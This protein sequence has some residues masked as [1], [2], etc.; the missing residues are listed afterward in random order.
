MLNKSEWKIKVNEMSADCTIFQSTFDTLNVNNS[1]LF[2]SSR[3]QMNGTSAN[4][5]QFCTSNGPRSAEFTQRCDTMMLDSITSSDLSLNRIARDAFE[6]WDPAWLGVG[7]VSVSLADIPVPFPFLTCSDTGTTMSVDNRRSRNQGGG[8]YGGYIY[9]AVASSSLQAVPALASIN[10][11]HLSV[12]P[13]G[14]FAF[15]C[16]VDTVITNGGGFQASFHTVNTA[17]LATELLFRT[18]VETVYF[19]NWQVLGQPNITQDAIVNFPATQLTGIRILMWIDL[20]RTIGSM[21]QMNSTLPVPVNRNNIVTQMNI[22]ANTRNGFVWTRS[23]VN[24]V[25][26]EVHYMQLPV[27]PISQP[28]YFTLVSGLPSGTA[29]VAQL[30]KTTT[31]NICYATMMS[32]TQQNI[33]SKL[34]RLSASGTAS[35]VETSPDVIWLDIDVSYDGNTVLGVVIDLDPLLPFERS[36]VISYDRGNTWARYPSGTGS[37]GLNRGNTLPGMTA[38]GNNASSLLFRGNDAPTGLLCSAAHDTGELLQTTLAAYI[39]A[40]RYCILLANGTIQVYE[41]NEMQTLLFDSKYSD[42]VQTTTALLL[43]G[44]YQ[45]NT[46]MGGYIQIDRN[47]PYNVLGRFRVNPDFSVV[48]NLANSSKLVDYCNASNLAPGVCQDQY[49]SQYCRV[50]Q[51]ESDTAD[52]DD[53]RCLCRDNLRMLKTMYN[54]AAL[55]P[56]LR[57]QLLVSAPCIYSRCSNY[58]SEQNL[59]TQYM[60][61]LPC[62][63]SVSI[64]QSVIDVMDK[65]SIGNVTIDQSCGKPNSTPCGGGCP[66]G[67]ACYSASGFCSKLCESSADCADGTEC[68]SVERVCAIRGPVNTNQSLSVGVIV[69]IVMALLIAIIMAVL[70]T[71]K[72]RKLPPFST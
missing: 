63:I 15:A 68:D 2:S 29:V 18:M 33:A 1:T 50:M 45:R 20:R 3:C 30:S 23:G 62:K 10:D 5:N 27:D 26:V 42:D 69:G 58:S 55:T 72:L 37:S 49:T 43:S 56:D 57:E 12:A 65:G 34:Y 11:V 47:I 70:I 51:P 67:T 32:N 48:E 52:Y 36:Y 39:N 24:P 28:T 46:N 41:T 25:E 7:G 60:D 53:P 31:H 8:N 19:E 64:C 71:L 40:N 16:S 17:T 44:P 6:N 9:N 35:I 21:T 38:L 59:T 61:S 4:F 66:I 14:E 22:N 54:D 13:N